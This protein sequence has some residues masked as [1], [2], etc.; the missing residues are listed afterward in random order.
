MSDDPLDDLRRR[1]L[2]T[3]E[4]YEGTGAISEPLGRMI[5]HRAINEG[6]CAE[7]LE[8]LMGGGSATVHERNG[9]LVLVSGEQLAA[10]L[11]ADG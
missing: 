5:L 8:C 4:Q 9:R 11:E 2:A 6:R 1:V 10:M 3:A 7:L